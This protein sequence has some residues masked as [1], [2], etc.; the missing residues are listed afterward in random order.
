MKVGLGGST[1]AVV[2]NVKKPAVGG[3][4]VPSPTTPPGPNATNVLSRNSGF[5][6][7][8]IISGSVKPAK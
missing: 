2:G 1:V 8:A 5:P 7:S 3:S 4:P 6:W